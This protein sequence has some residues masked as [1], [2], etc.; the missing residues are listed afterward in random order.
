MT[1]NTFKT[2]LYAIHNV[3][4]NSMVTHPKEII[5]E[6]LRDFFSQDSYYHYVDDEWGFPKTE[7]QTDLTLD[8]GIAD[9]A[10]TRIFIG[11][12]YRM[13]VIYYPSLLVRSGG[14]SFV[15][16]SFNNE[17]SA[18]Q[19]QS[20][21]FVDGYGN[22]TIVLTPSHFIKAGAW[23]GSITVDVVTKSPRSRDELI[24]LVSIFF[25]S[26]R[27]NQLDISGIFVKK[28]D[29]GTP[30]ESEDRTHGKLF[31]QTITC[32]IRSEWRQHVPILNVIDAILISLDFGNLDTSPPELAPNLSIATRLELTQE[33]LNL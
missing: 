23:E 32:Q 24:D 2:D 30:S 9:D 13:D 7:D 5:I 33:I 11:E 4:Q 25:A 16:I 15:P 28:V 18:V 19:W 26:L 10:T 31:S 20:T 17:E 22:E 27:R 8:A 3:I 14:A 1:A 12:P 6:S 29:A 21:R